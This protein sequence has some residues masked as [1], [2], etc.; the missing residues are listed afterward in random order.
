M[1]PLSTWVKP[2]VYGLTR[3]CRLLGLL[4]VILFLLI[5]KKHPDCKNIGKFYQLP[6]NYRVIIGKEYGYTAYCSSRKRYE[7]AIIKINQ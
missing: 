4:N 5:L 6:D 2:G 7:Y 3:R 1:F